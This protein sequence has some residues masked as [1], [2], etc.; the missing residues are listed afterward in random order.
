MQGSNVYVYMVKSALQNLP[1]D[2]RYSFRSMRSA[3]G[4]AA[5]AVITLVLGIGATTAIFS[6]VHAVLFRPLP[7]HDPQRLVHIVADD[8]SDSRSGLPRS[9]F[10]TLSGKSRTLK[11]L[12]IYYRNTGLSRVIVGGR[13]SPEQVQAGFVSNGLFPL[14]GVAPLVGRAFDESEVRQSALVGAWRPRY[15]LFRRGAWD[16]AKW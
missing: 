5:T 15:E 4:F 6:V 10:E 2:I 9:V 8:P 13:S 7:Y 3:P 14:L 12:A 1:A 16:V 11:H